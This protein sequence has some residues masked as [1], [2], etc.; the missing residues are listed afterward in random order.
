MPTRWGRS[1]AAARKASQPGL[2]TPAAGTGTS[3]VWEIMQS[4]RRLAPG[5]QIPVCYL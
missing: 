3:A 5:P 4:V 1:A 2:L